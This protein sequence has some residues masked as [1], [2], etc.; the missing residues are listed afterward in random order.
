MKKFVKAFSV[1][2]LAALMVS[3]LCVGVSAK[4]NGPTFFNVNNARTC[5]FTFKAG[6]R[7]ANYVTVRNFGPGS[8]V[9]YNTQGEWSIQSGT[10]HVF[11]VGRWGT[12]SANV[13]IGERNRSA[14]LWVASV[15]GSIR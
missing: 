6:S 1:L 15:D 13:K 3:I 14:D 11:K 5:S 2:I 10:S 7:S 8:I 9:V 12:F 4:D